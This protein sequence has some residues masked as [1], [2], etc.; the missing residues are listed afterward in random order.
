MILCFISIED[1][2]MTLP[3][4]PKLVVRLA[5]KD[6]IVGKSYLYA[7]VPFYLV[8][9]AMFFLASGAFFFVNGVFIL[10]L[11]VGTTLLDSRGKADLLFASLPLSR[12]AVVLGR[13][14]GGLLVVAVGTI[15]C[16]AYAHVLHSIYPKAET[17]ISFIQTVQGMLPFIAWTLCIIALYFPFYFRYSLPR[18]V[19]VFV[20]AVV[21]ILAALT[22]VLT[23]T[24]LIRFGNLQGFSL[25]AVLENSPRLV[26]A[27]TRTSTGKLVGAYFLLIGVAICISLWISIRLYRKRDF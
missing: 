18:G 26:E 17:N 21:A 19:L 16:F 5:V 24:W 20:S 4:T 2:K 12:G 22:M 13:Y 7:I 15:V 23:L 6:F 8:Y 14:I 1:T 9:G 27:I 11:T 10:A 3:V 25:F